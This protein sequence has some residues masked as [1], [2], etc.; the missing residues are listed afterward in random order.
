[1]SGWQREKPWPKMF[2]SAKRH[3][4]IPEP[5]Q[6]DIERE[7]ISASETSDQ[8]ETGHQTSRATSE[9]VG[10]SHQHHDEDE[11]VVPEVP[12]PKGDATLETG[13]RRSSC[14]RKTPSKYTSDFGPASRW[15]SGHVQAMYSALEDISLLEEDWAD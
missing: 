2:S 9:V 10:P 11:L 14:H 6:V 1:M 3:L 4:E 12:P 5:H 15:Q 7:R 13:Q 8:R